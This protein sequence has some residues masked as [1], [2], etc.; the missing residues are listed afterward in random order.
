MATKKATPK[1]ARIV[2]TSK[3]TPAPTVYLLGEDG[4][5][6]DLLTKATASPKEAREAARKAEAQS[7]GTLSGQWTAK[8][9]KEGGLIMVLLTRKAGRL[10]L[11]VQGGAPTVAGPWSWTW[12]VK[13]YGEPRVGIEDSTATGRATSLRAA[14]LAVLDAA[15][16]VEGRTCKLRPLVRGS[17]KKP[18]SIMGTTRELSGERERERNQR[19]QTDAGREERMRGRKAEQSK[20]F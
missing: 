17:T 11:T 15:Q 19:D 4:Q 12:A 8:L 2:A 3:R 16:D 10:D 13:R 6:V 18:G 9:R 14:S 20:L 5:A 1:P 7:A